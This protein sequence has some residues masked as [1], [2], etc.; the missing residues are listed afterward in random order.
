MAKLLWDEV[1]ERRYETG[2]DRGV[3]Y[4]PDGSA[5]PWNGLTSV[6]EDTSGVELESFYFDG[7]KYLE[8]RSSGD[9]SGTLKAFTFPEEFDV[10]DGLEGIKNGMQLNNQPVTDRFGISYRT[11]IGN[12]I[13][14]VAHGYKIHVIYNLMAIPDSKSYSSLSEQ[15]NPIE[16]SWQITAV[17]ELIP[18]YRPTAHVVFDTT[19]MNRFLIADLE[20][21]LYGKDAVELFTEESVI[22]GGTPSSAGTGTLDGRTANYSGFDVVDGNI[23]IPAVGGEQSVSLSASLPSLS[24]LMELVKNW[25]L[26][27]ITDNG[28][29]TWTANGSDEMITYLDSTKFQITGAKAEYL[30]AN[31]YEIS[32]TSTF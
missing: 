29:G 9:F 15:Q 12:D 11:L 26:I 4:L 22:D 27:E 6:N 25:V 17:P 10:L 28:D 32:T 16:F 1:G 31:T 20:A 19:R 5:V 7:F 14:G 3:L 13:N 23:L 2:V 18:G 24:V 8:T 21:L 30:N